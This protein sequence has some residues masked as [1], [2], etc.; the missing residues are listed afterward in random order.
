MDRAPL[1][2]RRGTSF[3]LGT[4]LAD[5]P[6]SVAEMMSLELAMNFY[7][8]ALGFVR[9]GLP[10][11]KQVRMV[12]G[13]KAPRMGPR[14]MFV[15]STPGVHVILRVEEGMRPTRIW[16]VVHNADALFDEIAAKLQHYS[17]TMR[18]YFP[19]ENFLQA[20]IE[21]K[22]HNTAWGTREFRVVDP[23]EN[24]LVFCE[25]RL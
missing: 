18:D 2:A 6:L 23:D 15:S 10:H 9:R 25:E 3:S 19:L 17:L 13:G 5:R 21:E 16:I 11:A 14:G 7:A 24:V 20:R 12:R 22:P 8:K 4:L 1:S